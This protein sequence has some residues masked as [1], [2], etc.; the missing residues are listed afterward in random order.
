V[1]INS[2]KSLTHLGI[3]FLLSDIKTQLNL[4]IW[5]LQRLSSYSLIYVV[6][7]SISS[8]PTKWQSKNS[9]ITSLKNAEEPLT[10][11]N[12][13]V[14]GSCLENIWLCLTNLASIELDFLNMNFHGFDGYAIVEDNFRIYGYTKSL[15]K[16]ALLH[17]FSRIDGLS[18]NFCF[19]YITNRSCIKAFESG[20]TAITI[21]SFLRQYAHPEVLCRSGGVL[22]ED[23]VDQI[24]L[25]ELFYNQLQVEPTFLLD[26]FE[27]YYLFQTSENKALELGVFIWSSQIKQRLIISSANTELFTAFLTLTRLENIPS[28]Y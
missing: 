10:N 21:I 23:V 25:W 8:Q 16:M 4:V 24:Q 26:E 7:A 14:I 11:V 9:I 20:I 28:I 17:L 3:K 6:S 15:V 12:L 13:G 22:T 18:A 27:S 19:G 1:D 2:R 5:E